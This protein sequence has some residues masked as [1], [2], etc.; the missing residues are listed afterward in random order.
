VTL[1]VTD[2]RVAY[3][4]FANASDFPDASVQ[5]WLNVGY[6]LVR[7][8]AW[9]DILDVGVGLFTAHYLVLMYRDTLSASRGLFGQVA[10]IVSSKSVDKVSVSYDTATASISDAGHW[11]QSSYG[12]RYYQ[13]MMMMGVGGIQL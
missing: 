2:F 7:A 5:Q 9:D 6:K 10:G 1:S 4:E 8:D 3:N 13:L 12:L 11:N